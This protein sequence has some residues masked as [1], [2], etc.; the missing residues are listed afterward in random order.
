[1]R[2]AISALGTRIT[3]LV[4]AWLMLSR[5]AKL[6]D[7]AIVAGAQLLSYLVFRQVSQRLRAVPAPAD[8]LSVAVLVAM[9]LYL[10]NVVALASLAAGLSLLRAFGDRSPD[11]PAAPEVKPSRDTLIRVLLF[12]AG[13]AVGAAALWFGPAGALWANAM[14]F[15]VTAVLA[16][17]APAATPQPSNVDG[18]PLARLQADPM[19]RRLAL[20]LFATNL[21]VQAGAVLLVALWAGQITQTPQL[22]GLIAA[23]FMLGLLGAGVTFA[24]L[25]RNG[26]T[27]VALTLGCLAGGAAGYFFLLSRPPQLLLVVGAALVTG[28]ATASVIPLTGTLLSVHVPAA[29]KS[30]VDGLLASVS[31]LGLPLGTVAA[32]WFL[33]RATVLTGLGAAAGAYLVAMMIPFFIFRT[34]RQ[35][36]PDAPATRAA[37][38]LPARL[39]VT[40]AY[41][42]GQWIVEVR[43]GR[44]LLGSRHLVKSAEAMNMLAVLEVP[45]VQDSVEKALA[46]DQREAAR[47]AERMRQE[48]AELEARLAGLSEMVEINE[49]H[50]PAKKQRT[51]EPEAAREPEEDVAK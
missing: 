30:K 12:V 26:A 31:Y 48:L 15:V 46:V 4:V 7:V 2:A 19:V 27:S 11:A 10:S 20:T 33:P 37:K 43:R 44:A 51:A 47:E 40:L 39:T 42:D 17:L 28:V 1:M 36:L 35:L 32:A 23:A 38:G 34:W 18:A 3:F 13:G 8:L 6:T 21:F 45:G 24:G 16:A 41:A 14:I 25:T 49:N 9:S 50:R 29:L 22:L 5:S